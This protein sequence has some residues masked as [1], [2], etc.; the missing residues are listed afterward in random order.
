MRQILRKNLINLQYTEERLDS[1]WYQSIHAITGEETVIRV[2]SPFSHNMFHFFTTSIAPGL[3]NLQFYSKYE[4][5]KSC[6]ET[7]IRSW[8]TENK[9]NP[10]LQL[11]QE[12]SLLYCENNETQEALEP[13]KTA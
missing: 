4:G 8:K 6:S 5:L 13:N 1:N 2:Q 10:T 9:T 7:E 3:Q 12:H 11:T